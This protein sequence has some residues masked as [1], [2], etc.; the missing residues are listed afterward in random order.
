MGDLP[1][2][3]D[4]RLTSLCLEVLRSCEA[5]RARLIALADGAVVRGVAGAVD[6]AGK[7]ESCVVE[8][9]ESRSALAVGIEWASRVTTIALGFSL[10]ALLGFGSIAGGDRLRSRR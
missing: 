1:S 10:P 7:R 4:R 3:T 6:A 2:I 5:V 9:P 8:Q